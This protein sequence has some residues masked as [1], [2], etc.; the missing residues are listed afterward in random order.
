MGSNAESPQRFKDNDKNY[1]TAF[2]PM[3]V[4]SINSRIGRGSSLGSD[5]DL[6]YHN[7]P[8]VNPKP[9]FAD[10]VT[11]TNKTRNN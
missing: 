5:G 1:Q 3:N 8:A 9:S 10:T 11:M 4:K 6:N 2:K 7:T